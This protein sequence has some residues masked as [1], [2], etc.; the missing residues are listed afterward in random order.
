VVRR[1][2]PFGVDSVIVEGREIALNEYEVNG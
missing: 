2:L 1:E